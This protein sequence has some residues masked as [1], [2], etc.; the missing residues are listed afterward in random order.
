MVPFGRQF[1]VPFL[2]LVV[3]MVE[4]KSLCVPRIPLKVVEKRPHEVATHIGPFPSESET[5]DG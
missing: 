2:C 5:I 1:G 4:P 3:D